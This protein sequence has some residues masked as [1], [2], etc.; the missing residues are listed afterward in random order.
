M[1]PY[2]VCCNL[3]G[4]DDYNFTRRLGA[5]YYHQYLV[6][7][8]FLKHTCKTEISPVAPKSRHCFYCEE[9]ATY[10]VT[11]NDCEYHICYGD[12]S[13]ALNNIE[14]K[15]NT[16]KICKLEREMNLEQTD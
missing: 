2:E 14:H 6:R 5:L 4:V 12:L 10:C 11:K 8:G 16:C 1:K 3:S 9:D 13:M 7:K 15:D